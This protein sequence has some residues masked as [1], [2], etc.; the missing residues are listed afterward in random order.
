MEPNPIAE[1]R[2][3]VGEMRVYY[4]VVD[5]ERIVKVKAIGI[6]S[7]DRVFVGGKEIKL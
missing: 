6:K 2:L 4:D 1:Y 5:A 3:R 7:R